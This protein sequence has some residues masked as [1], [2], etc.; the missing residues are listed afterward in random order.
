M[1]T[2]DPIFTELA[3]KAIAGN[4]D[5]AEQSRLG[6]LLQQPELAK[7]FQQLKADAAFAKEVLPLMGEEPAMTPPLTDFEFSQMRKLA[8]ARLKNLTPEKPKSSWSWH[9]IWGL[10]GAA[11]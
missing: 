9:W 1:K 11:A 6:E 10:A 8:E 2:D 4:A 5:S 7:E 3:L